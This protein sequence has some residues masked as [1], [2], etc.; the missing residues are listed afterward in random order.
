MLEFFYT[1]HLFYFLS[2]LTHLR[3][4]ATSILSRCL[5]AAF[6]GVARYRATLFVHQQRVARPLSV[7]AAVNPRHTRAAFARA[8]YA[9]VYRYRNA[10]EEPH[11]PDVRAWRGFMPSTSRL[12]RVDSREEGFKF[13]RVTQRA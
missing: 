1:A 9:G 12:R 2:F 8:H 13:V 11:V 6:G 7:L 4:E 10:E 3:E 5:G